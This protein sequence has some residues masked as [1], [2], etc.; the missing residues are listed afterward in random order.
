MRLFF[1]SLS[2]NTQIPKNHKGFWGIDDGALGICRRR[3]PIT[4]I[5]LPNYTKEKL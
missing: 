3:D 2:K 1:N 4:R 5:P